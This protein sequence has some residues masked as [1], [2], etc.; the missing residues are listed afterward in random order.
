ML[1]NDAQDGR[2][3]ELMRT[4]VSEMRLEAAGE[5]RVAAGQLGGLLQGGKGRVDQLLSSLGVPQ[6]G[7]TSSHVTRSAPFGE[8]AK[9]MELRMMLTATLRCERRGRSSAETHKGSSDGTYPLAGARARTVEARPDA[10]RSEATLRDVCSIRARN[11]V[12]SEGE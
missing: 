6:A 12:S 11:N 9:G 10:P 7:L 1:V 2:A 8:V 4:E 5:E 3:R